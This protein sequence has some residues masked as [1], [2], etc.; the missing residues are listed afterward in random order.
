MA[1]FLQGFLTTASSSTA[2]RF[3]AA[4][5]EFHA[6]MGQAL[7]TVLSLVVRIVPLILVGIAAAALFPAD[8]EDPGSLYGA[9][10]LLC[11]PVGLIG[12]LIVSELAGYMSTMDTLMN[13]GAS[14][15][16][17]DIYRRFLVKRA[18]ESHYVK[19][20]QAATGL[21]TLAG[22]LVAILFV[23]ASQEWFL[24]LNSVIG[25]FAITAGVLRFTWWRFNKFAE[26][27]GLA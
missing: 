4:K 6:I 14:L 16:V 26:L 8:H 12:L 1:F 2:Q 17:N 27:A 25:I 24:Y 20:G 19:V 7:A 10:I 15:F 22:V 11:A 9:M 23:T 3:A 13:W 21:M 5:N 18:S